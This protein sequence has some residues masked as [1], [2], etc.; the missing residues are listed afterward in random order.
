MLVR[1]VLRQLDFGS[2]VAEQDALLKNYFVETEPFR[3]L[4][5][6]RVDVIAGDKGTG[7]SAMYRILSEQY[8]SMSELNH[9]EVIS[10]FNPSGAPI[11]QRLNESEQLPEARY[12]GIWKAYFLALAG[13]WILEF[14][15]SDTY[16]D[17]MKRLDRIL[18]GAQLRSPD[19]TASGVFSRIVNFLKRKK[20]NAVE[21]T[22]EITQDGL[23]MLGGRVEFGDS[24]SGTDPNFVRHDDALRLLNRILVEFGTTFVSIQGVRCGRW[25]VHGL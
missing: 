23:P 18:R 10:A 16:T 15:D 3:A 7:K 20:I 12:A 8:A 14:F 19:D 25:R 9:I 17:E 5:E 2:S 22:A 1:D 21:G 13:N 24:T 6:G 4:V 11:F